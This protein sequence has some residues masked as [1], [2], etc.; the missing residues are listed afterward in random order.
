[1]PAV[2]L[3]TVVMV[4]IVDFASARIRARLV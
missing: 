4:M 2:L 1:M 3:V